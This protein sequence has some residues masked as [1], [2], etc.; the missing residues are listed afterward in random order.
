MPGIRRLACRVYRLADIFT[1]SLT[2]LSP[3]TSHGYTMDNRD[4]PII[5]G[6]FA[7]REIA[8][9]RNDAEDSERR[10]QKLASSS[11]LLVSDARCRLK[12]FRTR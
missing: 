10:E 6:D 3:I 12:K 9:T 2:N 11:I 4:R 5:L 8:N 1:A 7:S